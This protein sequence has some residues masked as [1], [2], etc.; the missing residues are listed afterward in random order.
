MRVEANK[1]GAMLAGGA[2]VGAALMYFLDPQ[3]GRRRRALVRDQLVHARHATEQA[4]QKT[5][6]DTRNRTEGLIAEARARARDESPDDQTL[7]DRVRADMGRVV[8]H[9]SSIIVTAEEGHVVVSGP[10]LAREVDAFVSCVR[11]V[12]GVRDVENRLEVHEEP[13]TVPGLQ[14]GSTREGGA[15]FE[16]L[17]RNWSPAARLV[18]G[19]AGGGL[20]AFG[21]TKRGALGTALALGGLGLLVRSSSNVELARFA[22]IGGRGA[23]DLQ[24]TITIQ[25]PVDV[26]FGFFSDFTNYPQFMSHVRRVRETGD[27]RTHWEVDGPAGRSVEWDAV[28]SRAVPNELIEWRSVPGSTVDN[29]GSVRFEPVGDNATRVTVRMTYSPPGGT[30]GKV[31]SSMLGANPRKE[32]DDD[33]NRLKTTIET[34]VPPHDAAARREAQAEAPAPPA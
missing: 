29:A 3:Q 8:S 13:G 15:R 12:R 27:G 21:A 17:Q 30:A 11:K 18:T 31:V 2:A 10:I 25:A 23:V 28:L 7:V 26:V 33:L 4:F 16:L 32:M 9:P 19:A 1:T 6:A 24:K 22:G 14:G 34:G 5:R 20:V